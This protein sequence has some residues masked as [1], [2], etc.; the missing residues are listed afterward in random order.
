[1][2]LSRRIRRA[3][4]VELLTTSFELKAKTN[5]RRV[6]SMINLTSKSD[7]DHG[8]NAALKQTADLT[9]G[10][11]LTAEN[12]LTELVLSTNGGS[13]LNSGALS[14]THHSSLRVGQANVGLNTS[15]NLVSDL[16]VEGGDKSTL[17]LE[18]SRS[19]PVT[20]NVATNT[21]DSS[22]WGLSNRLSRVDRC[23]TTGKLGSDSLKDRANGD[24]SESAIQD[25]GVKSF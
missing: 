8:K 16:S 12:G 23:K 6:L 25:R 4:S 20:R 21:R 19:N 14:T 17:S 2:G 5:T 24:T 18:L 11:N 3:L 15:L 1:M 9:V 7:R 13:T 22:I 10:V